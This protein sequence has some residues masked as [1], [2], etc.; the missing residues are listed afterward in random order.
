M[1]TKNTTKQIVTGHSKESGWKNWYS[2]LEARA[3]DLAYDKDHTFTHRNGKAISQGVTRQ[4]I[5]TIYETAYSELAEFFVGHL[6]RIDELDI[7]ISN[8]KR[9]VGNLE[10]YLRR[11]EEQLETAGRQVNGLLKVIEE[12][13]VEPAV[14]PY[15]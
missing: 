7:E 8:L 9:Q 13:V 11:V 5:V 2:I 6:E 15:V 4:Q 14:R 3:R 1:S 12:P 10:E